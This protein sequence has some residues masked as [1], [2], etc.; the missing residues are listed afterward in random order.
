MVD[1]NT[2]TNLL[3]QENLI[4]FQKPF[5]ALFFDVIEPTLSYDKDFTEKALQSDL[6]K[7]SFTRG[8]VEKETLIISKGEVVEGDKYQILKSLESEYESQVWTK[9]NYYWI[10]FGYTILVA[11][12]F[13]MLYLFLNRHLNIL[14]FSPLIS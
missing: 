12:A 5:I 14:V 7:I 13:L 11:L 6:D 4:Q 8:S 2:I 1:K 9:S 10:V 3:A